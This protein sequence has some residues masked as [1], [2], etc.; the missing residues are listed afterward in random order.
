VT[1]QHRPKLLYRL[2]S[3]LFCPLTLLLLGASAD[4]TP[5]TVPGIA[6]GP[7][8]HVSTDE[9]AARHVESWL[10][11]NPR[12]PH[13]LIAVSMVFGDRGGVAAYAS[14]D[15]GTNWVRATHGAHSDR[16]FEGLDPA[17]AFDPE[18]TAYLLA[19]SDDVG[20]WKS[21]DGGRSWGERVVVPGVGDRPFIGCDRSGQQTLRGRIYVSGKRSITVFGHRA[22]EWSPELDII[23]VAT[24]RDGAASF[25][26]PRLFLPAPEKELLNL[27]TDLLVAPMARRSSSFRRSA[28]LDLAFRCESPVL[29]DR[30][31]RRGAELL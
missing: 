8:L 28:E 22:A 13:N 23:T 3:L 2:S 15:G 30:F 18:G 27:V 5:E 6:V 24:S 19:L 1:H 26:F 16:V 29:D 7:S 9:P 31:R 10:A 17:V 4:P 14:H 21:A 12:D 11:I 25:G 20:V